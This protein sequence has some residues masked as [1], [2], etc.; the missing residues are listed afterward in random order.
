M[1]A[2]EAFIIDRAKSSRR[3]GVAETLNGHWLGTS[4][5]E[6]IRECLPLHIINRFHPPPSLSERILAGP[7]DIQFGVHSSLIVAKSWRPCLRFITMDSRRLWFASHSCS[8]WLV[9]VQQLDIA[10]GGSFDGVRTACRHLAS[11]KGAVNPIEPPWGQRVG[12]TAHR[13]RRQR[14]HIGIAPK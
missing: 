5:A 6:H 1:P 11:G 7:P 14:H 4:P 10:R 8:L 3:V 9:S 13:R 12:D 2:R